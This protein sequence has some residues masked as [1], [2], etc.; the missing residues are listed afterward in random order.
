[1]QG[2]LWW[3]AK[4]VCEILDIK[5]SRDAVSG[6]DPDEKLMVVIPDFQSSGRGGDTG[7][8]I[9]INEPGLYSLVLSSRKP[10]ARAFKRWIIHEVI[11]EI[12]QK[13]GH[14]V[15]HS[16]PFGPPR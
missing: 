1:M 4:E 7:R 5:N 2:N 16:W 14:H 6:L 10:E 13:G 15:K 11:P 12:R 9:I 8:R 3:V